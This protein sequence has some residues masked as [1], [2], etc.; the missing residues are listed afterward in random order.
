FAEHRVARK[1][2]QPAFS[3]NAVQGYLTVADQRFAPVIARWVEQGSV[4]FKAEIR[5]VLAGVA[6][7]IFTGIKDPEK[8]R[9]LDRSLSDFWHGMMA[10]STSPWLSPRLRRSRRGFETLRTWFLRLVP[11]R[12]DNGGSDLFSRMCQI[13]DR[14]G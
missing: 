11:E 13:E 9:V 14:E 1:V 2:V 6:A 4:A 12:R 10:L 8:I 7:E 3:L 5:T